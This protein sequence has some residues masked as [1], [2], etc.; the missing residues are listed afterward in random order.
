MY[1]TKETGSGKTELIRHVIAYYE[2]AK[3]F[4]R[5]MLIFLKILKMYLKAQY[6]DFDKE[7][8]LHTA[9]GTYNPNTK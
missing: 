5:F 7:S 8:N 4:F 1:S 6:C 3:Y 2:T 9:N